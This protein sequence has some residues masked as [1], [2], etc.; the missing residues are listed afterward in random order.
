MHSLINTHSLILLLYE[1][2]FKTIFN[3][4]GHI[5]IKVTLNR[6]SHIL[7]EINYNTY[8]KYIKHCV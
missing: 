4:L 7:K 2:E 3:R 8:K 1:T 5:D 6:Y